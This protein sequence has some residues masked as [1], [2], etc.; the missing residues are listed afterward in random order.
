MRIQYDPAGRQVVTIWF[1]GGQLGFGDGHP[2]RQA[3]L[4]GARRRH[5]SADH[6]QRLGWRLASV[7]AARRWLWAVPRVPAL[8]HRRPSEA[9]DSSAESAGRRKR[10]SRFLRCCAILDAVSS[11]ARSAERLYLSSFLSSSFFKA[12]SPSTGGWSLAG[13]AT[14]SCG[15]AGRVVWRPGATARAHRGSGWWSRY[16][17]APDR[18]H[19]FL[20]SRRCH[21]ALINNFILPPGGF[22]AWVQFLVGHSLPTPRPEPRSRAGYRDAINQV[23]IV[24]APRWLRQRLTGGY[25]AVWGCM[26]QPCCSP[27]SEERAA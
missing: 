23:A 2:G 26:T 3:F 17:W 21:A 12:G 27:L 13:F 25:L 14:Q 22:S 16:Q 1:R 6:R 10:A 7:V 24:A 5:D 19:F 15:V 9:A 4:G 11:P 20:H 8:Y 18:S